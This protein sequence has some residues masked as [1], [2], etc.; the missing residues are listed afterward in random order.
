MNCPMCVLFIIV[1]DGYDD[2]HFCWFPSWVLLKQVLKCK[3]RLVA[4][5]VGN[6]LAVA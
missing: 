4:L 1:I 6:P 5:N 2:L 3:V